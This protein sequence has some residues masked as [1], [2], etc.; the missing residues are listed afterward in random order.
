M[1]FDKKTHLGPQNLADRE[2]FTRVSSP[3]SKKPEPN[4]HQ[5]ML[6]AFI[7]MSL[8]VLSI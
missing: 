5:D 1:Y 2:P 7:Q 6:G 3:F 4:Y 8:G